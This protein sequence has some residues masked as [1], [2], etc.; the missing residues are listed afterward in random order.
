MAGRIRWCC[1]W[2]G[3]RL[4]PCSMN[5]F[6]R[7]MRVSPMNMR[8]LILCMIVR[9]G[10]AG[11][12]IGGIYGL[13]YAPVLLMLYN[14]GLSRW[15]LSYGGCAAVPLT[16]LM[17]VVLGGVLGVILAFLNGIA[18]KVVATALPSLIIGTYRLRTLGVVTVSVAALG[19][20]LACSLVGLPSLFIK[21]WNSEAW[22]LTGWSFGAIIPASLAGAWSWWMSKHSVMDIDS[23]LHC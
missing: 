1:R 12:V 15:I 4:V 19:T 10:S 16:T 21:D 22:N 18:V 14:L 11:A 9:G 13:F 7:G 6:A 5:H 23:S 3:I 17:G 2:C 8:Q 20:F